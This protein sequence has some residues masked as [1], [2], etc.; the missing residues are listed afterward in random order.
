MHG[1]TPR[2]GG[3][4]SVITIEFPKSALTIWDYLV[5]CKD[6]EL[7]SNVNQLQQLTLLLENQKYAG[8]QF[9]INQPNAQLTIARAIEIDVGRSILFEFS[10]WDQQGS[11]KQQLQDFPFKTIRQ[12]LKFRDTKDGCVL[13]H[14]TEIEPRGIFGWLA[15]KFFVLP[16]AKRDTIKAYRRLLEYLQKLSNSE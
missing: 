9:D 1:I 14:Y 11:Q 13:H 3:H 7:W 16:L 8:F 2:Q 5:Y 10:W 4:S 15:C 12:R 6:Y